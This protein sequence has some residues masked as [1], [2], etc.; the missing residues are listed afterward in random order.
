MNKRLLAIVVIAAVAMVLVTGLLIQHYPTESSRASEI[1]ATSKEAVENLASFQADAYFFTSLETRSFTDQSN[2][3]FHLDL[4]RTQDEGTKK[5]LT[6]EN[7]EYLC[8]DAKRNEA[9]ERLRAVLRDAWILDTSGA[10]Y[11][12]SPMVLQDYVT[13]FTPQT[14]LLRYNYIPITDSLYLALFFD[15]AENAI[16][17]GTETIEVGN[18]LIESYVVSYE[19]SY[20]TIRFAENATLRTWISAEDYIPVKTELRATSADGSSSTRFVFGFESYEKDVVIPLE[21]VSLPED[22]GV[23]QR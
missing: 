1:L 19:F 9:Y 6:F 13:Q 17:E 16:Y 23:I 18:K 21:A 8:S 4:L 11:V 20:P 22:K 3:W 14:S 2:Y 10:F 12:Y 7:Y 15:R 5:K